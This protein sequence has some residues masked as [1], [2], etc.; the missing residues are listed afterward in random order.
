MTLP[1]L[2]IKMPKFWDMV[3]MLIGSLFMG[4]SLSLFLVPAKITSGGV[5]GIAMI[6]HHM[7]DMPT[8]MVM[9]ALNI[10]LFLIGIK[11]LGA[12]FG[13][14]TVIGMVSSS[15]FTD[16]IAETLDIP[17]VT[18]E[19]LLASLFGGLILG[20]GLGLIFRAGGSTGGSDIVGSI[21]SKA[22]GTSI[23]LAIVMIDVFVIAAAG[24]AFQNANLAL[25]GIISLGVSS[26]TIDV[27]MEGISYAR[28]V[29]II[30]QKSDVIARRVLNEMNRGATIMPAKGAF[31]GEARDVLMVVLTR[32]E[33]PHL[34]DIVEDID[35]N[36]FVFV[37]DVYAVRGKG[38]R[39]RGVAF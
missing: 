14:R 13:L 11:S 8:G 15:I 7:A 29:K 19:P 2:N 26:Y 39:S 23:G 31:T 18:T 4:I 5:S 16:I 17:P 1:I 24:I 9:L 20:V 35:E 3:L 28:E 36:A 22:T 30:S 6:L 33:L 37:S 27:V 10:P 34:R 38:F 12:Q 32:K 25:W 21:I